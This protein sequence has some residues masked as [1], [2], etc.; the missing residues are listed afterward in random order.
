MPGLEP[1]I[2]QPV[3]QRY[4]T[5]LSQLL[6]WKEGSK[7]L[8]VN[9]NRRP[10]AQTATNLNRMDNGRVWKLAFQYKAKGTEA[11]EDIP[12]MAAKLKQADTYPC[13]A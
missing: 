9:K 12:K 5:E 3:A 8:F 2:I 4:T 7:Y 6:H 13:R 11:Q 1:P 10:R